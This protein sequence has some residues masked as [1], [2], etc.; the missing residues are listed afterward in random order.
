MNLDEANTNGYPVWYKYY[1]AKETYQMPSLLPK[2]WDALIDKLKNDKN[3]FETFHKYDNV[4]I[5]FLWH[6]ADHFYHLVIL[7]IAVQ[8]HLVN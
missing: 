6:K 3:A 5:L 7:C 2:D 4:K 8:L 1:N